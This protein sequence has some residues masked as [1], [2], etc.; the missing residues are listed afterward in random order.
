MTAVFLDTDADHSQSFNGV[1]SACGGCVTLLATAQVSC[2]PADRA[3]CDGV[4][5]ACARRAVGNTRRN[6]A[7]PRCHRPRDAWRRDARSGLPRVLAWRNRPRVLWRHATLLPRLDLIDRS[8]SRQLPVVTG[9]DPSERKG[10]STMRTTTSARHRTGSRAI[11]RHTSS[12]SMPL[13]FQ[14]ARPSH[15]SRG[16]SYWARSPSAIEA[17]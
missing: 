10:N 12:S 3:R 8:G 14:L 15:P 1:L 7:G 17:C 9:R 6:D 13:Q 4:E 5:S 2:A 16:F 11:S